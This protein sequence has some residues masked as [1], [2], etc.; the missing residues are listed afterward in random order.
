MSTK[1]VLLVECQSPLSCGLVKSPPHTIHCLIEFPFNSP[2]Y[3]YKGATVIRFRPDY[4]WSMAG[5]GESFAQTNPF[6]P[7]KT[8]L[9]DDDRM[10]K[11]KIKGK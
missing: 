11:M 6:L 10:S 1:Q 7:T 9:E 2:K 8:C 4:V 5:I 3:R